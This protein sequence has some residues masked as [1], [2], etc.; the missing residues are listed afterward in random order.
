MS[1]SLPIYVLIVP[2]RSKYKVVPVPL[3]V[4]PFKARVDKTPAP[5]LP[6]WSIVPGL[7]V[8]IPTLEFVVS[9]LNTPE[10]TLK[11]VVDELR[12]KAAEPDDEVRLRAP[13][14][15]VSPLDAVSVDEKRPVPVTSR[16]APGAVVPMPTLPPL[17][18][19][20]VGPVV[21]ALPVTS[22]K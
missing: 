2:P 3:L 9:M 10:L 16:F 17:V 6:T 8:L 4:P 18:A 5:P 14:V 19:R 7:V 13:V 1:L 11:A 21:R 15:S 12:V 22:S 20:L